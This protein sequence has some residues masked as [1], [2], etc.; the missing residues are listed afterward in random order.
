MVCPKAHS[1]VRQGEN[2][3]QGLASVWWPLAEEAGLH[4]AFQ[5]Q[6]QRGQARALGAAQGP[7][8]VSST[9]L[10]S[11]LGAC[12]LPHLLRVNPVL[13]SLRPTP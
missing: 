13:E 8:V 2:E 12:L 5:G 1:K 11:S 7:R 4:L 9:T 3:A 6:A 10:T